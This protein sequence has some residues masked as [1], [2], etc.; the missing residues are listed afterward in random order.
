M[1]KGDR[2]VFTFGKEAVGYGIIKKVYKKKP[3]KIK[4]DKTVP[5]DAE[6]RDIRV[7]QKI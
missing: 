3:P 4:F 5:V 7:L 6:P 2:V 1:E